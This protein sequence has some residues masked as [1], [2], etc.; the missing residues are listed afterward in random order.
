M[1]KEKMSFADKA[2]ADLQDISPL[3]LPEYIEKCEFY[4]EK[5]TRKVLAELSAEF[6]K[7]GGTA[8]AVLKPVMCSV[9]DGILEA[10]PGGKELRQKGLT[11]ERIVDECEAFSYSDDE[12]HIQK[13]IG[14]GYMEFRNARDQR[15]RFGSS[16][17][18]RYDAT[19]RKKIYGD[20]AAMDRYKKMRADGCTV[21][22]DEYTGGVIYLKREDAESAG[23]K[24]QVANTDHILSLAEVQRTFAG[25]Y[26]LSRKDIRDIANQEYNFAMTAAGV[27]IPKS[28][29]SVREYFKYL[30][31]HPDKRPAGVDAKAEKRMLAMEAKAKRAI[32]GGIG[33]F[34][35]A[36]E[37]VLSNLKSAVTGSSKKGRLLRGR[38]GGKATEQAANYAIGN[39]VLYLLKP[40]YWELKDS[41]RNGFKAGAKA[42][43][44]EAAMRVRFCR[45]KSYLVKHAEDFLGD[46]VWEFIKGFVSSLIEG[47]VGLFVGIFQSVLKLLKEGVRLFVQSAKIIWGKNSRKMTSAEK[48]DAIIK[49]IGA[50]VASMSGIGIDAL[51]SSTGIPKVL[52]APLAVMFSGVA[53]ALFMYILDRADLFNVRADRRSKMICDVFSA[54]AEEIKADTA[55]FEAAV[56]AK[57]RDSWLEYARLHKAAEAAC[58]N[59]D[60]ESLNQVLLNMADYFKVA[61]PYS[62]LNTFVKYIHSH[63]TIHIGKRGSKAA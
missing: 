1:R 26:V 14:D 54:R 34:G 12:N 53:S 48:G 38:I 42:P 16:L 9:A 27:N 37:K 44:V 58:L 13:V 31:K 22:R 4:D 23:L 5:D 8:N 47:L 60:V 46:N 45:I 62:D 49:L 10:I 30:K 40:L 19:M 15:E 41:F 17:A 24:S 50:S 63:Q 28:D 59:H 32:F 52:R 35:V 57:M 51:L 55:K 29:M 39:V 25:N 3:A 2:I 21:L 11:P 20:T 36:N 33:E 61:L 56:V 43:S 7:D 18:R 6:D